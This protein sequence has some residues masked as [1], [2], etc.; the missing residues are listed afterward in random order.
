MDL[1]ILPP[2]FGSDQILL[3]GSWW[4]LGQ[5]AWKHRSL[6]HWTSWVENAVRTP[7]ATGCSGAVPTMYPEETNACL[8]RWESK[9]QK[10]RAEQALIT[11]SHSATTLSMFFCL[12]TVFPLVSLLFSKLHMTLGFHPRHRIF[13]SLWSFMCHVKL[14]LNAFGYVLFISRSPTQN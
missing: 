9:H 6:A 11:F 10:E 4:G 2:T 14:I 7:L 12:I 5:A 1:N 13:I 3:L 8:P